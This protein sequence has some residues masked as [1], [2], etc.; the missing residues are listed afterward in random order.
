VSTTLTCS[1]VAR[2]SLL[3]TLIGGDDSAIFCDTHVVVFFPLG[4]SSDGFGYGA[5][6]Y[7]SSSCLL[8]V[9]SALLTG[10]NAMKL[11]QS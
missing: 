10:R 7:S 3:E 4:H 5:S 9:N 11:L 8:A 1:V 2:S 6:W